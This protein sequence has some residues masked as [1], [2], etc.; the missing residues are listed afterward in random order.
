MCS[1]L[2]KIKGNILFPC[3]ISNDQFC[4]LI[5]DYPVRSS[6]VINTL[7]DYLMDDEKRNVIGEKY[8]VNTGYLSV[9]IR[10]NQNLSRCILD[11][12]PYFF[13]QTQHAL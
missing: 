13:P 12:Y 8:Q 2:F 1:S 5:D 4:L 7:Q 9:K 3:Q 11:M 6:K 10:E